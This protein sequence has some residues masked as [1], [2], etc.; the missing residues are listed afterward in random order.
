MHHIVDPLPA[1]HHPYHF[2][3]TAKS[4]GF[5]PVAGATRVGP[6]ARRRTERDFQVESH[7]AWE[8]APANII[9][10]Q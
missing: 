1:L 10:L 9:R 7:E 4:L 2:P 5:L 8:N 6:A 3:C